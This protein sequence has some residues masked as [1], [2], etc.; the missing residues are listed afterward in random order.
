MKADSHRG[1]EFLS[2]TGECRE[3]PDSATV[4]NWERGPAMATKG[5]QRIDLNHCGVDDL[6]KLP[7]VG[8]KRAENLM[9]HRPFKSWDDVERVLGFDKGMVDDLKCGGAHL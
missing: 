1:A 4:A 7:M 9:R 6:A 2:G 3:E 8:R 5:D